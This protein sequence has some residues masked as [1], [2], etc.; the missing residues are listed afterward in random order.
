M[1]VNTY[2][3]N[4]IIDNEEEFKDCF[5][6]YPT[7]K[8]KFKKVMDNSHL[9][10][11][12]YDQGHLG[13]CVSNALCNALKEKDIYP[14]RLYVYYNARIDKN[15]DTGLSIYQGLKTLSEY[16]YC[17]EALYPY[18][19]SKFNEKPNRKAYIDGHTRSGCRYA[20]IQNEKLFLKNEIFEGRLIIFGAKIY[21]SFLKTGNDAMVKIPDT[22]T[23]KCLGSHCMLI[24]GCNS[25]KKCYRVL[26][27]W[28][29]K[30]CDNGLCWL[31]YE[32]IHNKQ[33]C[34]NFFVIL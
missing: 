1:N 12:V 32:F 26:N 8:T 22:T 24:V 28:S 33:L 2:K 19:I 17:K 29:S 7:I 3:L 6:I 31:P 15:S 25:Y 34:S 14:S 20:S 18:V 21:E 5:K 16:G 4:L 27:S 11:L 13:S 10:Q 9:I 23:E 30:W